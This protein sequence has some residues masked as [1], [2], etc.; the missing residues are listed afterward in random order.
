M[1]GVIPVDRA[2]E[3]IGDLIDLGSVQLRTYTREAAIAAVAERFGTT[4]ATPVAFVNA[5]TMLLALKSEA[6]AQTLEG[7]LLFNDGIGLDIANAVLNGRTFP[8]NLNGTDFVPNLLG[9]ID[10]PIRVFLLGG[11]PA[12]VAQAAFNLQSAHPRHRVV[13]FRDGYFKPDEAAAVIADINVLAPDLLL[14]G[15]GNPLQETFIATHAHQLG[16]G[17]AMGVGGLFDFMAGAVPRA[18]AFVRSA[19]MEWMFRLF[20]EP[21]RLGRRYTVEILEFLARLAG[22]KVGRWLHRR[23]PAVRPVHE[24]RADVVPPLA[25]GMNSDRAA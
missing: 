19:G 4:P 21:R 3:G 22:L 12:V 23:P 10:R 1:S 13:G 11:R 9:A 25:T 18:P 5:H 20:A 8:A 24:P 6:Y 16:C 17:V 15:M 2:T 7:F 14:V